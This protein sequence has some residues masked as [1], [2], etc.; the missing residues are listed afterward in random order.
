MKKIAICVGLAAIAASSAYAGNGH[1]LHGFGPVNSSM[2]GAGAALW[3]DDPAAALMFNPALM[4]EGEGTY[5]TFGTEFF[6]DG[7]EVE[8]TLADGTKGF[9]KN[10]NQFGVLPTFA[11]S[12]RIEN[13]P[14][15]WGFGLVGMAGFRTDF[16]EDPAGI[17]FARSGLGGFGRLYTDFRV[18]KIPLA[19]AYEVNDRLTIGVALNNYVGELSIS[20]NPGE[21]ADVGPNGELFF[22]EA[23]GLDQSWAW[24]IQPGFLYKINDKLALG[25]SLTTKQDFDNYSW[26]SRNPNPHDPNF[27][28]HRKLSFGL[29][30]PL[31]IT[32]GLGYEMNERTRF[33]LDGQ[34]IQYSGVD[35][36]G[37]PGGIVGGRIFSFGW[38][39][40][41]VAKFGFEHDVNDRLSIRAGYNF[42]TQVVPE[43]NVLTS[44][45]APSYFRHHFAAGLSYDL[46][47]NL[48][49]DLGAY[50][51]PRDGVKG[52]LPTTDGF[53]NGPTIGTV[54][55]SNT[56]TSV[57]VGL[58]WTFG[59]EALPPVGG[60]GKMPVFSGKSG[61]TLSGGSGGGGGMSL[62]DENAALRKRVAELEAQAKN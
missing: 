22:A 13:T 36:F 59:G 24:S 32:L 10:S 6:E 52:P 5:I 35:G 38:N 37:S 28:A 9:P 57:Q 8:V 2:G 14:V 50:F 43:K 3:V 19:L 11:F 39:D 12:T 34:W 54:E 41:Y 58:T 47:D 29:D 46:T 27:G 18:I 61:R 56:L 26:N 25:G 21:R 31:M 1:M 49:A 40:V 20:P 48:R 45:G 51:V 60:G 53:Q 7:F 55:E 17:L 33:A 42:N 44:S 16:R 30:G 15:S 62:E 23:D 4:G